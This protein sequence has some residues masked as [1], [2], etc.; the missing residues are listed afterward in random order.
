MVKRFQDMYMG[1]LLRATVLPIAVVAVCASAGAQSTAG[2][3]PAVDHAASYY[4][5]GLAKIYEDQA[6]ASGRQDTAT[7]AIEQYKLAMDADPDSRV[8]QD[9]IANLYFRLGRIGDAVS[10]A[11][12]QIAKHPDDIDAHLLLGRVYLRTLGDGQGPQATQVLQAA[13]K[14]YETIVALKPSSLENRLLL[15][16][17]YGL[18]HDSAKAEE[19]F[20]AAQKIDP[21]NEEVV[22][23]IARQYSEQGNLD[24]AAKVIADV[25]E[26][27][28]T[29][30]MDYALAGLYDQLKK[31]TDAAAAYKAALAEDPDNTDAKRGLAAALAASGQMD[32]AAKI[33]A[34]I[35]KTDPQDPQALIREAEIQ[36]QKGDFAQALV[37][38]KKAEGLVS[39]GGDPEL[40]Y[41]EAL[42]YDGLGRFDD[43]IKTLKQL[44]ATRASTDGKYTGGELSNRAL[45]LD[46]LGSAARQ[47]GNTGEAIAAFEQMGALGGDYVARASDAEVDTYR[48]A[49]Q[50]TKALQVAADAAKAMPSN[51]DVQLTYARQ[52]AD[53]GKVNEGVKLAEAQLTGGPEDREVYFDLADM[54]VRAKRWKDAA[55]AFDKADALATKPE[56]KIYVD[57]FR[58]DAAMREKL[59]D[60]AE[61]EFRKG[62]ALDPN[63]AA[64]ENDLGYMYADRG[65]KLDEAVAMLKKAVAS[66]PQNY[67]YLDSLAWAYYKQ[68]QYAMA[69]DYENKA[70][71]RM[72]NDPTVLDHLGEIEARNGKLQ[73]AITEWQKSLQEY[74]D[75]LP[76]EADPED[77]AK[78]Q[79]K[80]EKARVRL[81]HSGSAPS[82]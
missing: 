19:Q 22:L 27:D 12:D 45:F 54:D 63:N 64:I 82:K 21:N 55:A 36:R 31:P 50:W 25:P 17:L 8:L 57:Y 40:S 58:G 61:L 13:I 4:H 66:D 20:K 32:A 73:A 59:Y 62:L 68:G 75:S 34:D 7:Q 30:R 79:R 6:V 39:V 18:D 81:A 47:V 14:E 5:Y 65:I 1:R 51:H 29:E 44:L 80:L 26:S 42:V 76:P 2:T 48:E 49:H 35:L 37:T 52:L 60:E 23:S 11:Q 38:L 70:A 77:V 53:A 9:G 69:E 78:V 24:R 10:A 33:N 41:N 74:S 16:Q 46:L 71:A 67:A 56:D 43:A 28:R 3:Q 15:G 72:S